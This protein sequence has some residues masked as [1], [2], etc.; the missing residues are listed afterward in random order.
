TAVKLA[1]E[2]TFRLCREF[3]DEVILVD[4]DE[5][6]AA[7]KDVF[8]ETRSI[9]EPAGALSVAGLKAYVE[10]EQLAGQTLIAVASGANMNFDR[11]RHVSERSELGEQR[12][13][14][15]AVTIPETPGSFKKFISLVGRRNIT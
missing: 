10:R 14:V 15:L 11:L 5:I 3:L 7:I 9:L 4:T 1:G 6:C 2:E 8:E 13:A 12:E